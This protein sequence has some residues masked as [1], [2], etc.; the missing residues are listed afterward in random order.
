M[1]LFLMR[2]GEADSAAARD[3]DRALTDAGKADVRE[4]AR[5]MARLGLRFDIALCS[6]LIRA[7][8]TAESVIEET[9]PDCPLVTAEELLP[10]ST[11]QKVYS[12]LAAAL[13]DRGGGAQA[14]GLRV[15]L[16]GHE[17]LFGEIC[18]D[19]MGQT[20][21]VHMSQGTLVWFEMRD[22]P[23]RCT[24]RLREVLPLKKLISAGRPEI[25]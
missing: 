8:E 1:D 14:A 10:D 22:R 4:A 5:G 20:E 24:G 25:V 23:P 3:E 9:G 17:P 15:L 12:A 13:P 21:P 6:P 11:P 7:L 2:H 18:A 19:L 16:V